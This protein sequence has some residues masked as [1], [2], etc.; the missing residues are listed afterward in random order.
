M[1]RAEEV[2]SRVVEGGEAG[3]GGEICSENED[4]R[5]VHV[6]RGRIE[7]AVFGH[8]RGEGGKRFNKRGKRVLPVSSS[9]C[10]FGSE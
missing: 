10:T 7:G 4:D 1:K 6:E 8:E 5:T 3:E 2:V 9:V